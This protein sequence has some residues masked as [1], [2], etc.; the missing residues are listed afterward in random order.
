[1]G[2]KAHL[3]RRPVMS[4]CAPT[5]GAEGG[6][7]NCHIMQCQASGGSAGA[8]CKFCCAGCQRV[9]GANPAVKYCCAQA[10]STEENSGCQASPALTGAGVVGPQLPSNAQLA[11]CSVHTHEG[12]A[13]LRAAWQCVKNSAHS[14]AVAQGRAARQHTCSCGAE[15]HARPPSVSINT[16]EGCSCLSRAVC[17]RQRPRQL[18]SKRG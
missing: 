13:G 7:A 6:G 18:Q 2:I 12:C 9:Q 3:G 11:K 8:G 17:P 4:G 14:V 5:R 15:R 16:A 1:M 10:N